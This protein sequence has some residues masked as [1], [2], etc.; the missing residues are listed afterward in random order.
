MRFFDRREFLK[1]SGAIAAALAS[2][3]SLERQAAAGEK[4]AT[5]SGSANDRLNVAVVGVNG[6]GMSHVSGFAGKN[7]C[8]IK[9]ICDV[10]ATLAQREKNNPL[11]AAEAAQK[12]LPKFETDIRK[13]LEDKSID[14]VSIA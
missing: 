5:K 7:N 4:E 3:S 13:V 6:R 8:V 2:L 9:V 11:K 14:I 12:V 10:D 1:N